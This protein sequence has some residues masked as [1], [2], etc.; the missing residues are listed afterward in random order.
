MKTK[1]HVILRKEDIKPELL[2][3]KVALVLDILCATS[4]ITTALAHQI[5]R[6]IPAL[7]GEHAL[8]IAQARTQQDYLLA[9]EFNAETL[10][11]F[12]SATPLSIQQ[13]IGDKQTLIYATTN[14]TI[15]LR[16]SQTAHAVYAVSLLNA[17]AVLNHVQ[18]QHPQRTI[19]F[20]CSG[21]GGRFNM[22]DFY[23][24]GYL[25]SLL[26]YQEFELSDA[27][28]AALHYSQSIDAIDCFRLSRVGRRLLSKNLNHELDFIAQKNIY[29][30]VPQLQQGEI[31]NILDES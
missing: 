26:P 9:G 18:Q 23:G 31:K 21:S 12:S 1:L 6:V 5:E 19:L 17:Q 7:N 10:H 13:S 20:I 29:D 27:A 14:G 16:H 15:A 11:G 30:I 24:A 3:D 22:E 4:S 2:S 28:L 25:I 8:Q